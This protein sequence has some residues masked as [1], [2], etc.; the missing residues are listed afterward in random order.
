MIKKI[1]KGMF[2]GKFGLAI[3]LIGMIFVPFYMFAIFAQSALTFSTH[4]LY[5]YENSAFFHIENVHE[6]I[7]NE[8]LLSIPNVE[9]SHNGFELSFRIIEGI[10]AKNQW[11]YGETVRLATENYLGRSVSEFRQGS[12]IIPTDV[13]PLTVL[14]DVY[15]YILISFAITLAVLFVRFLVTYKKKFG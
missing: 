13:T 11:Q 12:V 15:R 5:R 4:V 9:I 7:S 14:S 8:F 3:T 10:T 1:L 2:G 6:E